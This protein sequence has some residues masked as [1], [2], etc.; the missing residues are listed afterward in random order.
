MLGGGLEQI[1]NHGNLLARTRRLLLLFLRLRIN[2]PLRPGIDRRLGQHVIIGRD[3]LPIAPLGVAAAPLFRDRAPVGAGLFLERGARF[4]IFPELAL[5]FRDGL[6]RRGLSHRIGR[7]GRHGLFGRHGARRD[8]QQRER[9]KSKPEANKWL[10]HRAVV[11]SALAK[12]APKRTEL[13][14]RFSSL[15]LVGEGGSP[16]LLLD[17]ASLDQL[18]PLLLILVDE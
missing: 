8:R 15:L 1:G 16:L 4:L 18:R 11:A 6:R 5:V 2:R 7:R 10:I 14:W 3:R 9:D 12:S 17:A 13:Q